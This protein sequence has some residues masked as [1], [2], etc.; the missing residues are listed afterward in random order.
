MVSRLSSLFLTQLNNNN[1]N[2]KV[3]PLLQVQL[4]YIKAAEPQA[5]EG[6]A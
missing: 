5:S 6:Q 1:N 3:H 2:K 4:H